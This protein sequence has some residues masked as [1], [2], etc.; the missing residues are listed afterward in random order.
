MATQ[1]E[2]DRQWKL[3][4]HK[5][6]QYGSGTKPTRNSRHAKSKGSLLAVGP[7]KRPIT[8]PKLKCLDSDP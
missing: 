5:R 4:I 6:K 3:K 8:L 1:A 2:V 7:T